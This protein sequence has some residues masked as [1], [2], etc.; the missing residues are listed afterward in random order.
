MNAIRTHV[1]NKFAEALGVPPEH[2]VPFNMEK[3]V[4]NWCGCHRA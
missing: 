3:S 4:F 1:L 2:H